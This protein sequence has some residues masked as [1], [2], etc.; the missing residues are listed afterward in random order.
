LDPDPIITSATPFS[1]NFLSYGFSFI[2]PYDKTYPFVTGKLAPRST[3]TAAVP[4]MASNISWQVHDLSYYQTFEMDHTEDTALSV[5]LLI[6]LN[7][8]HRN[9]GEF[10]LVI[11]GGDTDSVPVLAEDLFKDLPNQLKCLYLNLPCSASRLRLPD[12]S[13]ACLWADAELLIRKVTLIRFPI[14]FINNPKLIS[15]I[16]LRN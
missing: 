11:Y 15:K 2:L 5:S 10:R 3:P 9:T 4:T 14:T 8:D 6:P 16:D 1:I 13:T 12:N 7:W